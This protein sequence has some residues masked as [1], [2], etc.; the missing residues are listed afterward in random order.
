MGCNGVFFSWFYLT[1]SGRSSDGDSYKSHNQ[2]VKSDFLRLSLVLFFPF[3]IS[4]CL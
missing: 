1:S 2:C 3:K 4:F